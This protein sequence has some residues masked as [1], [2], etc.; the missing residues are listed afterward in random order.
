MPA[1]QTGLVRENYLWKCVLKRGHDEKDGG[2]FIMADN[3]YFDHDIFSIIWGPT[4]AAL[5]YVF[6]VSADPDVIRRALNGFQRCA[7]IAAHYHMSDVFDNLVISLCKFT[8]LLTVSESPYYFIPAFGANEKAMAATRTVFALVQK[9]GDILRDGWKNVTECLLQLFK[10]KLLP[11]GMTEAEDFLEGSGRVQLFRE[12]K[13][14]AKAEP[15]LLN[16]FV[17][18]ISMSTEAQQRARTP[19]EEEAAEVAAKCIQDCALDSLVTESKFLLA[20]SLQELVKYLVSGSHL[21]AGSREG[22]TPGDGGESGAVTPSGS[23]GLGGGGEGLDDEHTTLFYL[24]MLVRITVQNRD[25]VGIIWRPVSDHLARLIVSSSAGG[26]DKSFLLERSVTALLRL[27]VRLS[28][29]EDLAPAV[30]QSL[31]ILLAL[32]VNVIFVVCRHIAFGLHE[33]LR[34]NAAN[35]H[36][37]EDWAVIFRLIE[38]VG[39]GANPNSSSGRKKSRGGGGGGDQAP[40]GRA[41]KAR[42]PDEDSG[43]GASSESEAANSR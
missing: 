28:R 22:A 9:H 40:T 8:T 29:K 41:R 23:S 19:E 31:R 33:L 35:I 43:H 39:A 2:G 5:S 26:A 13:Q 15:G 21:D 38:V 7:M 16:S 20:E 14:A 36:E 1:E 42:H 17:S 32:K 27:A 6:S 4:V 11:A 12:Q 10:C 34:N 25:R 18:F 37:A 30:V 24:E 3:G